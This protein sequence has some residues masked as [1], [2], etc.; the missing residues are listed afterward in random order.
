MWRGRRQPPY[1]GK[2]EPPEGQVL[3]YISGSEPE[4]LDPQIGTGQPEARIHMALF[5]GLTEYDPKTGAAIPALAERWEV[6]RR[7]HG[8]SRSTCAAARAG[9]TA[10][11]D[12]RRRLRLHAPPRAGAGAGGAQRLHGLRHRL[13]AGVQRRRRSS[14]ATLHGR[15]FLSTRSR[16]RRLDRRRACPR[17]APPASP[18]ALPAADR[19]HEFVPVR[20]ED[21]GVDAIDDHT[22]RIRMRAAGAVPARAAGA[23]V[24]PARAA[25]G[26]RAVRR[27][28][29]QP[30]AHRHE[31]RLSCSRRWRPYDRI[32]VVRNPM[33]WDAAASGST[34]S[35]SIRSKTDDDDEPVQG[36]RGGRRRTTTPC[37][38]RGSIRSRGCRTTW[39]RPRRDRVLPVQ[40]D[41]AADERRARRQ[42]VQHGDRQGGAGAS[43]G[44]TAKP[45]TGVRPDGIFPGYPQPHG[46]S[47]RSGARARAAGRGRLSGCQPATTIRRRSRSARSRS[48]TTRRRATGR[49][50]SSCR[51]NGSRISG[52][53][54][55]SRTW[56]SGRS[57]SR[58]ARLEYSGVARGGW[59]GDYMDPF[60]FLDLFSTTGGDNGTGWCDPS[61]VRHAAATPTAS[62]TR[63]SATRCSRAPRRMLLDAQPIIPLY[64]HGHQLAE[65]AVREGHVP[66]PDDACTPG[67]SSTS[68]TIRRSGT[69]TPDRRS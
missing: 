3:R 44:A 68:S 55:R 9:P 46:R 28:V 60:T 41:A 64:T 61:Y 40:H 59:I 53:P 51:R 14:F 18:P 42:G 8:R 17:T 38:R 4:S 24:L 7:Q 25:A 56:S 69:S 33:Y 57:W 22:V 26:D 10:H 11:A 21:I 31:R 63:A 20:A 43:S 29:D 58:R 16:R 65:E 49:S 50:P 27:R 67:S 39:T 2:T 45:L 52:S 36:G 35:R 5:D 1:F 66:E 47:V 30:G 13:R 37:R 62:P 19:R 23:P 12:H 6:D 48:P 32:V 34:G 15:Q 54:C